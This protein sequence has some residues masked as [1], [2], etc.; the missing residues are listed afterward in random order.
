MTRTHKSNL[1]LSTCILLAIFATDLAAA[2]SALFSLVE[3]EDGDTIILSIEGKPVRLQLLGIDAP[4][5]TRNP[6]LERDLRRTG[7]KP[8]VLLSI[9]RTATQHLRSA[10]KP[11]D[12]IRVEGDLKKRDKYGRIPVIA[13]DHGGRM[14]NE[15]MV[16]EGFAI[17][18][19]A[20]D[21]EL[22]PRLRKLEETAI[23]TGRGI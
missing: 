2:E 14:M 20:P 6:K 10:A 13:F 9:G 5:D 15:T 19:G 3:I 11:G 23:A 1:L 17:V 18:L 4:E 16:K 7:L 12:K 22:K 8:E 21:D